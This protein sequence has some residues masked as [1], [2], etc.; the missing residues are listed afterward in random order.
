MDQ[1]ASAPSCSLDGH[2]FQERVASIA[3]FHARALVSQQRVGCRLVLTYADGSG[4]EVADMVARERDCCAFLDFEIRTTNAG[5][6][7]TITVPEN[8]ADHADALLAPF[9]GSDAKATASCCG[10]C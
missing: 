6:V 1:P 10:T 5:I 8:Q 3:A 4:P 7:L 9:D 2:A